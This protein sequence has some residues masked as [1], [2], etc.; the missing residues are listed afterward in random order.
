[1]STLQINPWLYRSKGT[2]QSAP[3]YYKLKLGSDETQLSSGIQVNP[4][5]WDS[6]TGR[7]VGKYKGAADINKEI[8]L[9]K[10]KLKKIYLELKD[11]KDEVSLSEL[12]QKYQGRDPSRK[13]LIEVIEY[14]NQIMRTEVG[15]NFSQK[16]YLQY[17]YLLKKIKHFLQ[18]SNKAMTISLKEVDHQ[19]ISEFTT[20]MRVELNNKQNTVHK[21]LTSLKKIVNMSLDL[22][23]IVKNPFRHIK[24]KRETPPRTYL[25]EQ[26]L[27]LLEKYTP[28]SKH[29]ELIKDC[30]L[31]QIYT[32]ASYYDLR[33]LTTDNLII[34]MDGEQW[35]VY[36]R[37]KTKKKASIPLLPIAKQIIHKYKE[38]DCRIEE[39]LLIPLISNQKMNKGIKELMKECRIN[40]NISTHSFRRTFATT[41]TVRNGVSLE[42]V[43]DM[44]GQTD[45][46]TTQIYAVVE[47]VKL[48]DEMKKVLDKLRVVNE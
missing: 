35:I 16:T 9:D 27:K 14:H 25:T 29:L 5:A 28:K 3:I 17:T 38:H 43:R 23:W 34:G 33:S 39:K 12:K 37:Q 47:D 10:Q 46:K 40:K 24:L 13:N 7:V 8:E 44:L 19:F 45:I 48:S 20:Y 42:S 31:M 30:S 18:V 6:N 41:I 15:K 2:A 26:E 22:E 32:G 36:F 1:M 4:K 21:S 11:R